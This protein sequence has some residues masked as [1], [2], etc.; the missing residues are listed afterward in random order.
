MGNQLHA[1]TTL[2]YLYQD[3][4]G[5]F[6]LESHNRFY[7]WMGIQRSRKWKN[8]RRWDWLNGGWV[9]KAQGESVRGDSRNICAQVWMATTP[10]NNVSLSG[11][12]S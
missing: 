3:Y 6:G 1:N 8:S 4:S 11:T 10:I 9:S 7:M 2:K 5:L 12:P